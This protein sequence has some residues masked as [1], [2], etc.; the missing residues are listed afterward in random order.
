MDRQRYL[1]HVVRDN[2]L[3]WAWVSSARSNVE[4]QLTKDYHAIEKGMSLPDVKRPFVSASGLLAAGLRSRAAHT[5]DT[6]S[7]S[8]RD[9]GSAGEP[10]SNTIAR[11]L[12][13]GRVISDPRAFFTTRHS[14]PELRAGAG[15]R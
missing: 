3:I 5:T 11:A 9:V 14:V 1:Q 10:I 13:G 4:A 8:S 7:A 12:W 2:A 6:A 15:H